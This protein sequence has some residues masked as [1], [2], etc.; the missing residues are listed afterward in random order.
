[1]SNIGYRSDDAENPDV[2]ARCK[3]P[4]SPQLSPGPAGGCRQGHSAANI[5]AFV[6]PTYHKYH[7]MR[8]K[9]EASTYLAGTSL[10]DK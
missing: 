10:V 2:T 8:T 3:G 9:Y 4:L 6:M 7:L 5:C 1:M